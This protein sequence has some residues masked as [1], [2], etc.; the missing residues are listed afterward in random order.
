MA[1][2]ASR[3]HS[4]APLDEP[5]SGLA[6]LEADLLAALSVALDAVLEA[7]AVEREQ[8]VVGLNAGED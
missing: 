6:V 4:T 7:G 3:T 5:R 8:L 2:V 1:H